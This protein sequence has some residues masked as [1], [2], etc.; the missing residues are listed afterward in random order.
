MTYKEALNAT[1][2]VFRELWDENLKLSNECVEKDKIIKAFH[3]LELANE[4][5]RAREFRLTDE[6]NIVVS[7]RNFL[8]ALLTGSIVINIVQFVLWRL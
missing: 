4:A 1:E 3:K 8:V 6:L 5:C 7:H 2:N